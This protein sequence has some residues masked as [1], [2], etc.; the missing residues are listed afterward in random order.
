MRCPPGGTCHLTVN[1]YRHRSTGPG[2]RVLVMQCRE[3]GCAFT[4]YPCGYVP[5]ARVAVAPVDEEG[6]LLT[7]AKPWAGTVFGAALEAADGVEWH[8]DSPA[9]DPR[10]RRTQG[11]HVE[12]AERLLGLRGLHTDDELAA[13]ASALGITALLLRDLGE[14]GPELRSRGAAVA[15]ALAAIPLGPGVLDAILRAG[16]RANLWGVAVRW[17]P[18]RRRYLFPTSGTLP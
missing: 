17:Q 3:H 11:R 4:L 18:P 10:R 16:T 9:D 2:H 7:G 13:L 14:A 8:R 5:Y 12:Q 6:H 15:A 1:H